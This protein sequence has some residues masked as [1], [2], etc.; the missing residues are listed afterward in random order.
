MGMNISEVGGDIV[1][2]TIKN[3]LI[4]E[5]K[6]IIE[7]YGIF[8]TGEVEA[9]YS[10][11]VQGQRGNLTHLIECFNQDDVDVEVYDDEI[12]VDS[13][14]LKYEEL[15]EETL[16]YILKLAQAYQEQQEGEKED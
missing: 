6:E 7:N 13:Y 15:D 9:S 8:S 10:P 5:I 11:T 2:N 3:D 12:E 4:V 14:S 16:E 1:D